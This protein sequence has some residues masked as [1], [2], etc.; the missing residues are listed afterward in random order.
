ME[1]CEKLENWKSQIEVFDFKTHGKKQQNVL[2]I[3][4]FLR[5]S[6][7]DK[8]VRERLENLVGLIAAEGRKYGFCLVISA[9]SWAN[10]STAL[11]N[12]SGGRIAFRLANSQ[13]G[14]ALV[15]DRRANLL[16]KGHVIAVG[17][18]FTLAHTFFRETEKTG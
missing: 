3:D 18:D 10:S 4:E 6:Q 16:Q 2:I 14:E 5:Y 7:Q 1:L 9:Q 17:F 13:Q 12:L 11:F 15:Q 8:V